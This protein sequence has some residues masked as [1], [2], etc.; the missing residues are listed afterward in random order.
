MHCPQC[1][2]ENPSG[3]RFCNQCGAGLAQAP[4]AERRQLTVMFCDLA[5]STALSAQLDPEALRELLAAYQAAA[6]AAI[7]RYDGHVAQY[8]GDGLLVY[9]GFPQA[10]ED[11]AARAVRAGLG[12]LEALEALNASAAEVRRPVLRARIGVHTGPVV[13]GEV[14][15]GPRRE[16]LAL[17]ETPNVA[18]RLQAL[19][20]PGSVVISAA[21]RRLVQEAFAFRDLG[22]HAL[23]GLPQAVQAWQV[24]HAVQDLP[25]AAALPALVGR[26]QERALL[27]EH[28]D[29]VLQGGGHGVLL[30]GEP[31]MGKTRLSRALR[32]E[33]LRTGGRVFEA[34]CSH[35]HPGSPFYPVAEMI[36][37]A[38]D[39]KPECGEEA[40][41]ALE[42]IIGGFALEPR[43]VVPYLA[44]LLS[45]PLPERLALPMLSAQALR[46][47]TFE[48]LLG[49][50]GAIAADQPLLLV[51]EDLQWSDPSTLELIARALERNR[52]ARLLL[53]CTA[54]SEFAPPTPCSRSWCAVSLWRTPSRTKWSPGSWRAPTAYRCSPRSLPGRCARPAASRFPRPCRICSWRGSIASDLP[55]R[56]R[57]RRL[58][59]AGAFRSSCCAR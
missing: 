38:I 51:I 5:D 1:G 37:R 33:A 7:A 8:L 50:L 23:K 22:S 34:R 49:L 43:S 56:W 13:V 30:Q 40:V 6:G 54:R 57:S 52:S 3:A 25:S 47:R 12:I 11:A 27:A 32:E 20:E 58:P 59:S 41:G 2:Q 48:A 18:A 17:G 24:T 29:R 26:E 42:S 9:F 39:Y 16:Q 44:G 21:T 53:L 36:A 10:H 55:S 28:W 31:G 19:A 14:G 35:Y 4:E 46:E 45:L 15:T